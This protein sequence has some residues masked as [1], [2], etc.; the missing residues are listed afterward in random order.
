M[1]RLYSTCDTGGEVFGDVTVNDT[2]TGATIRP[3]VNNG[4]GYYTWTIENPRNKGE[5]TITANNKAGEAMGETNCVP[6]EATEIVSISVD[7]D[8]LAPVAGDLLPVPRRRPWVITVL[9][10]C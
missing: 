5:I 2:G 1:R 9:I 3:S 4:N 6:A 7:M 8:E 10:L